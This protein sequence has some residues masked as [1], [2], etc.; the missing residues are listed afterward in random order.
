MKK[1]LTV[2]IGSMPFTIDE[3]AYTVLSRYF[4]D[5]RSRLAGNEQREVMEDVEGR[6]ADLF[7][8]NLRGSARVV[9]LEHVRQG[10]AVIGSAQTF[11]ERQSASYQD[12]PKESAQ[13]EKK[14]YRSRSHRAIA[15]LCGGVA[16]YFN[17][18]VA[19]IRLL[20]FILI[21]FGGLSLWIYIIAW[22]IVP[23]E[24][25]KFNIHK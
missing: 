3:D 4:D 13:V 15:G 10:I 5:I 9:S 17:T 7:T 16:E 14:F 20:T 6:M 11:G 1:T 21:F 8:E 24:P 18:D 23:Q 12:A 2:N 22:I 25:I 19:L